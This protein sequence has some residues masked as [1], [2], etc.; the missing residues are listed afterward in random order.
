[1]GLRIPSDE[2]GT[3]R[4]GMQDEPEQRARVAGRI[5]GRGDTV[6]MLVG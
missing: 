1:M 2:E 3:G 5:H 6:F 4:F